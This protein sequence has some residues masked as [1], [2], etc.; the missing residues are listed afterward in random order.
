MCGYRP[1]KKPHWAMR[2]SAPSSERIRMSGLLSSTASA[3]AFSSCSSPITSISGWS[4]ITARTSSRINRGWLATKTRTRFTRIF[5]NRH[6][7]LLARDR[8]RFNYVLRQH[9]QKKE[10][11]VLSSALV[12]V[13]KEVLGSRRT[14]ASPQMELFPAHSKASGPVEIFAGVAR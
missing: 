1:S 3:S 12:M 11:K 4:A 13:L 8:T 14:K 2:V 6:F 10:I 5:L 7:Y 9:V